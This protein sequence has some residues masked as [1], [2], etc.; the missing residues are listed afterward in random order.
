MKLITALSITVVFGNFSTFQSVQ[1]ADHQKPGEFLSVTVV[2]CQKYHQLLV[3]PELF[4]I[5]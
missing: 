1:K 2:H 3:L 4:P 5:K